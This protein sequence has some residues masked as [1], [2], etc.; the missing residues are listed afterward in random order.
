MSGSSEGDINWEREEFGT[1]DFNTTPELYDPLRQKLGRLLTGTPAN[2]L[3]EHSLVH[4]FTNDNPHGDPIIIRSNAQVDVATRPEEQLAGEITFFDKTCETVRSHYEIHHSGLVI[5]SL[6]SGDWHDWHRRTERIRSM[7][8]VKIPDEMTRQ[9][10]SM[11]PAELRSL[12]YYVLGLMRE[13]VPLIDPTELPLHIIDLATQ[14]GVSVI[15]RRDEFAFEEL[16]PTGMPIGVLNTGIPGS[17][18][19]RLS[20]RETIQPGMETATK[21]RAHVCQK[22]VG[23]Q[24][25]T[26]VRIA[27]NGSIEYNVQMHSPNGSKHLLDDSKLSKLERFRLRK[28]RQRELEE[29]RASGFTMITHDQADEFNTLVGDIV[30]KIRPA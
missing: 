16:K 3:I 29:L 5:G 24:Q 14:R 26:T 9:Q 6:G 10:R 25:L 19:V 13:E 1:S 23:T 27:E 12:G 15:D 20:D 7:R 21:L 22:I 17:I 4:N 18:D 8:E 11:H 28:Q 30:A 2:T